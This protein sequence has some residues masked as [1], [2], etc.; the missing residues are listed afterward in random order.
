MRLRRQ[1]KIAVKV[2]IARLFF[3]LI[4]SIVSKIAG[5]LGFSRYLK[6][7]PNIVF[8]GKVYKGKFNLLVHGDRNVEK[9][10]ASN[11]IATDN[12]VRAISKV[13]LDNAFAIDIGANVGTVSMFMIEQGASK[14]Y[15]FEP[16][17][18]FRDLQNNLD[19][20]DLQEKVTPINLGLSDSETTMYWAEDQ[21]NKGNAHLLQNFNELDLSKHR[22]NFGNES[23][24]K[25]V[26]VSTLDN[27][28]SNVQDLKRL[29]F[30]KIDVEGLE[31]KV[32]KGG[33]NL[34]KKFKPAIIAETHRGV[35][36]MFGYDCVTPIFEFLYSL[37]YESFSLDDDGNIEKFLYPNF[38]MDT[39]FLPKSI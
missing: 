15:A 36:D 23:L 4:P 13:N 26:Q 22:T 31:W 16:G 38:K 12:A 32:I 3:Q 10:A 18:L 7:D 39:L 1:V 9:D 17:P 25:K 14:V 21:N 29:D 33:K 27:Y 24:L 11:I 28:F 8:I 20:N 2:K 5:K 34:I 35:S 6:N 19:M 30:I 37:D